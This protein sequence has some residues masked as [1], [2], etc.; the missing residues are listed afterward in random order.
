MC[1]S[2][3]TPP[4]TSERSN[5]NGRQSHP[6]PC[7]NGTLPPGDLGVRGEVKKIISLREGV[8]SQATSIEENR[9]ATQFCT[10]HHVGLVHRF[11]TRVCT[12]DHVRVAYRIDTYLCTADHAGCFSHA[13]HFAVLMTGGVL[14]HVQ[15][16][17][18]W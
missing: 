13:V 5:D 2:Y 10:A 4:P 3:S 17:I 8:S 11:A 16:R 7:I 6:T 18:S 14:R 12:A 15:P 1:Y 9:I